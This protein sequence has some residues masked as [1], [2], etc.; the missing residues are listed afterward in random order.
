[1]NN[2]EECSICGDLLST[3]FPIKLSCNHS[4]HYEC[5]MKA[6]MCDRKKLNQCPLCRRP[7]GLLP[8]VNGLL[9]LTRGIHYIDLTKGL[10]KYE[11][12]SCISILKSGKRKGLQCGSRCMIGF[13]MCK[14]HHTANL[15]KEDKEK[16]KKIGLGY[17][18]EQVQLEQ[19]SEVNV[20]TA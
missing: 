15:K 10:P 16:K 11:S 2:E 4:Y 1:M 9:R 17:S 14:R 3:K 19:A 6:F 7:H 18:L 12:V 13:S 20:T 5:I 8:L